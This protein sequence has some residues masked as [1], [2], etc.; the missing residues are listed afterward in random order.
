MRGSFRDVAVESTALFSV[1]SG[2]EFSSAVHRVT[3]LSLE[4]LER[5]RNDPS[6]LSMIYRVRKK[7]ALVRGLVETTSTLVDVNAFPS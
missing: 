7:N 4:T 3:R 1:L 2:N 5:F 6:T